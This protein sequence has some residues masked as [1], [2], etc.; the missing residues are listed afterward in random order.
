MGLIDNLSQSQI[1]EIFRRLRA[2]ENASPMNSGAVGEGGFEVY[3]GGVITI[4]NGGLNVTGTAT[5]TGTLQADGTIAF[6]GTLTQSGPSTFTGTTNLNGPTNINGATTIAGNVTSTGTFT[7][8]GPTNLNGATKTTGTLSV[9]GVTTLKNDL[10]VTTGKVKAGNVT[11]DPS[12]LS[13][14]VKFAN[15][16]NLASTPNGA[17]MTEPGGGVVAVGAGQAT[18]TST[19]G[20]GG[21]VIANTLSSTLGTSG[22]ASVSTYAGGVQVFGLPTKSGVTANIYMDPATSNLYRVV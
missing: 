13:G 22:G 11:I 7:N 17:Q 1:G 6:T 21:Y 3:N 20:G 5:I 15:G 4:S 18:L 19:V 14:S 12:Y 16:T 10:N 2:L 8:N 9:E